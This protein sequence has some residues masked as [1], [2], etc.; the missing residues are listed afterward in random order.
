MQDAMPEGARTP[1][2][3]PLEL[4]CRD[5]QLL[6]GDA[7]LLRGRILPRILINVCRDPEQPR[8]N[9][10]A[11]THRTLTAGFPLAPHTP[12]TSTCSAPAWSMPPA[13]ST[14]WR[15]K[16]PGVWG[17]VGSGRGECVRRVERGHVSVAR[18][19]RPVGAS[20]FTV[21]RTSLSCSRVAPTSAPAP[22]LPSMR[23]RR[24]IP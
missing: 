8:H 23:T 24:Q 2:R 11:P 7:S 15:R 4:L 1:S 19:D 13:C 21:T 9:P 18:K 14:P 3:I 20:A 5:R 22:A 16:R 10:D 12:H 17:R 6:P